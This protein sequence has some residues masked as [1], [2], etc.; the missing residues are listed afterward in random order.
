MME[1]LDDLKTLETICTEKNIHSEKS[2]K[3]SHERLMYLYPHPGVVKLNPQNYR[4]P[5]IGPNSP[6]KTKI[7]GKRN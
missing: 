3:S 2:R 7:T 1:R 4:T 5:A 6:E